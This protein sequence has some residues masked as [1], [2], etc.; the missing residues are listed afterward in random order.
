MCPENMQKLEQELEQRKAELARAQERVA[1]I[2][3]KERE[4][5]R[6]AEQERRQQE[7]IK[8]NKAA[9]EQ[10]FAPVADKIVAEVKKQGYTIAY[11][12]PEFSRS[13]FPVFDTRILS[14][15]EIGRYYSRTRGKPSVRVEM[16]EGP[17][18]YPQH[19]DGTFNVERI[20]ESFAEAVEQREA[21]QKRQEEQAHRYEVNKQLKKEVC[22]EMGI[23]E[24]T[25]IVQQNKYTTGVVDINLHIGSLTKEQAI[26]LLTKIKEMGIK[27]L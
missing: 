4:A 15:W 9:Y 10:T 18:T 21:R 2:K 7:Q 25:S 5:A 16:A 1:E 27:A 24:Y 14:F 19:K 3:R 22:E 26:N 17:R 23:S 13:Y 12:K 8:A 20:A 11:R 6:K